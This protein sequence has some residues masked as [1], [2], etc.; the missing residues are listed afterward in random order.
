MLDTANTYKPEFYQGVG[1][2]ACVQIATK[3]VYDIGVGAEL[4]GEFNYKQS[5]A[6]VRF[7]LFFSGA[8]RGVKRNY[9]PHVRPVQKK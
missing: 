5:L 7:F 4:F 6:G 2:Y 3:L 1:G 9:N 8:Y